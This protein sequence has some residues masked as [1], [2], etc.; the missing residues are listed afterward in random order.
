MSSPRNDRRR[1]GR[2]RNGRRRRRRLTARRLVIGAG[3]LVL[4]MGGAALAG[5]IYVKNRTGSIYHPHSRFV[6]QPSAAL[7][8]SGPERFAWPIYG[9]TK[10]H[11]RY[12]PAGPNVHPPF[13][14]LWK[15]STRGLLEFPPVIYGEDIFQLVDTGVLTAVDKRD[16]H[17]VW[18]RS[19]G[20]LSASTPAVTAN[21]LYATVLNNG[22]TSEPGRIVA[23][24]SANG[25][26]RWSRPL[27]SASE[28]SPL[29]DGGRV[30]F[31][32]QDGTVYA[33][34]DRTGKT[35]WTYHAAGA[36]KASPTLSNGILYF[37]DYSGQV[38]AVSEAT[39]QRI[40]RSG[41]EG[42][43]LGSGTFYS[44]AAVMYGRVYLGNT[45]GRIYAY[46]AAAGKL[47]WA[48]QTGN[49]VYASPAVTNAPGIGPTIYAGSYDGTFYA[50]NADTGA[51]AWKFNGNG[52][53]SGS[54]TIIGTVVY[55]SDLGSKTIFGLDITTGK[56]VYQRA[57]GAFDPAIS[58][59]IDVYL[60]G[61]SSL[62]AMEPLSTQIRGSATVAGSATSGAKNG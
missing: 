18:A 19:I 37:G 20:Q 42:A 34:D 10:N 16:G 7:P 33:L 8:K 22:N 4:L 60:T 2:R 39:G 40:W 44:T 35:I 43:V 6:D 13:R 48:V 62:A 23:V 24:N 25:A 21:T 3:I 12:F 9:Y 41:S 28:S 56:L 17:E 1:D 31:G 5:Y 29:V 46:D 26:I 53:I 58:D 32:S 52:R 51:T 14:Q 57:D 36:V 47:D 50:L 54:A 15:H 11:T 55:F 27:P 30:F 61:Y 59:G 45:D 49:Y 38:Q